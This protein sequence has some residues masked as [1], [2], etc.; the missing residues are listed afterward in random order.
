MFK[1]YMLTALRNFSRNKLHSSINLFGLAIAFAS[2]LL[3]FH[4]IY[5]ECS[6]DSFHENKSIYRVS[7]KTFREGKLDGDNPQFTAPLGPAMQKEFP[8]VDNF[9]RISS[10]GTAFLSYKKEPVKVHDIVYADSSFFKIFSFPL[11]TGDIHT[12]LTE[13]YSIVLTESTSKKIFGQEQSLEKIIRVDNKSYT[14]TGIVQD[15]PLNS[16]IQ[17]NALISFVSLYQDPG[18]FMDWNGGQRYTAYVLLNKTASPSSVNAKLPGLLWK[19][20]NSTYAKFNIKLEAYLQPLTDVHLNYEPNS[21]SLR[22]NLYIFSAIGMFILLIA[23]V[24]FVNLTTARA[25]KRYKE[26]GVRKVL[27]ATRTGLVRQFLAE[28]IIMTCLAFIISLIIVRLF[29]SIYEQIMGKEL[30]YMVF[31]QPLFIVMTFVLIIVVGIGAG[32]YPAF[33]ISRFGPVAAIKGVIVRHGKPYLRNGLLVIQFAISIAL[34]CSTIVIMQQQQFIKNKDL[35]FN[36]E[37]IVVL[38]LQS[39]QAKSKF[40]L[41]KN[42]IMQLGGVQ[43]VSG[44][45]DVPVW[46]FTSNGYV[47]EGVNTPMKINVVDVDEDFLNTY[48][49]KLYSGRNFIAGS[50]IDSGAYLINETL[51]KQLGWNNPLGKIIERNKKHQVIGVVKDFYFATLHD[52]IE[53]LIITHMPYNR[54]YDYLSVHFNSNNITNLLSDIKARWNQLV[55]DTPFDYFFLSQSFDDL[56][57]SEQRFQR[58]FLYASMLAIILAVLGVLGLVS[59]SLEQRNKEIG[60]RKVCGASMGNILSLV[61]H[62]FLML[63]IL[64]NLIAWPV[65][66]YFGNKW[67][68]DFAN[69]IAIGWWVFILG[70]IIAL[71]IALV[72]ISLQT[73]RAA[74]RNPAQNLRTE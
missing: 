53:P 73:I 47:P 7:V 55:Y 6:F 16:S 72:T 38:P 56:Y 23:C 49:I 35:G 52:K 43:G 20:I 36:K 50:S 12:A 40:G 1:N 59:F 9:V 46:G 61:S 70:G 27:G 15:P 39:E 60:I 10:S 74:S 71:I 2:V 69:R 8:E 11:L 28:S 14:V 18:L 4:Y 68:A 45:S 41:L 25:F 42:N 33:Y 37:N 51:A 30:Y 66:W 65:A 57:K 29:A 54:K 17:F 64:S 67:L 13:P 24:N 32:I 58:G 63:I 21:H 19:N 34:I 48:K 26:V 22:S 31:K 44:S 62:D 3:I 5:Q